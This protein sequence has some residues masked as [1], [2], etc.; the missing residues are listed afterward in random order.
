MA[1]NTSKALKPSI[2]ISDHYIHMYSLYYERYVI[3]YKIIVSSST[4]NYLEFYEITQMTLAHSDSFNNE[5]YYRFNY[6]I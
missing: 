4:I 6:F 5:L 2:K 1:M 3:K